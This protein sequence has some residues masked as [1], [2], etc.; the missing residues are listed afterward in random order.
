[1]SL[2]GSIKKHTND[3]DEIA[4]FLVQ[5]MR[6][7]P[8]DVKI[9][10][11]LDA[12]KLLIKHG[13]AD[14]DESDRF[15]GL[16][17][18]P[19]ELPEKPD[20]ESDEDSNEQ[21]GASHKEPVSHLD[22]LNYGIARQ[23][24]SETADGHTIVSFLIDAMSDWQLPEPFTPKKQ[25]FTPADRM[26]AAKELLRRGFGDFNPKNSKLSGKTCDLNDWQ[27]LHSDLAKRM[28][29]Y[30]DDGAD[31]VRFLLDVMNEQ[32]AQSGFSAHHRI[33]AA[34]ELLRRGWDINFN[35]VTWKD[36]EDYWRDQEST[37]LS[38]G[39]KKTLAGLSAFVDEFDIYDNVDYEAIAKQLREDDTAVCNDNAS[40]PHQ[41]EDTEPAEQHNNIPAW[42]TIE[43]DYTNY[44]PSDPD[45]TVDYFYEPLSPEEQAK[46][47]E[48]IR[49]EYSAPLEQEELEAPLARKGY[50]DPLVQLAEAIAAN[51]SAA[52]CA[53]NGSSLRKASIRSP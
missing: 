40:N 41:A 39:Q 29:E 17:P 43:P 42:Q 37:R 26:A 18:T 46:F 44:G 7:V 49:R 21:N 4:L 12:A 1:M 27:T 20:E 53:P 16:I 33:S 11:R 8:H 2:A 3:G 36:V 19:E 5:T 38:V 31:A 28:R 14:E 30:S 6:G 32:D 51:G 23:I 15:W 25:R 13:Y 48:E 9:N 47:D 35:A 10:H 24:R 22:I 52:I 45:P 34:R 50:S